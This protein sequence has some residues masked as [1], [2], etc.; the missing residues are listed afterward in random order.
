M[1]MKLAVLAVIGGIATGLQAAP[2]GVDG[3]IG[4][5]WSGPTASVGFDAGAA[6]GNFGLPGN[7]NHNV[8]YDTYFRS[9]ANYLYGAVAAAGPTNALDFANVYLDIDGVAGSDLGFE[10]T[11]DRFFIPGVPGYIDDTMNLLHF[12]VGAGVIE[13]AVDWSVLMADAYGMG[14]P[15]TAPGG[16]VVFRLSQSFGY[17][18]AGGASYGADRLGAVNAP[19]AVVPEPAMAGLLGLA[20]GGLLLTRR[21]PA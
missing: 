5:E 15:V 8:A 7:V 11:L 6:M 14:I 12:S 17:S 2:V 10:V 21:R 3:T 20:L 4:A 19:A 9:D 1:L 18:V 13:F 16:K